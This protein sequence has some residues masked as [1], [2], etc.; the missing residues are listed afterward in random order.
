MR[1]R[2]TPEMGSQI[3]AKTKTAES[4]HRRPAARPVPSNHVRH[5]LLRF[6]AKFT[7]KTAGTC[8]AE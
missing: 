2:Y 6:S 8:D 7:S 4:L 5:S 1:K 3:Q